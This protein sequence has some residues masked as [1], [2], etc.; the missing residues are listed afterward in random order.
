MA[1]EF[2]RRTLA[3]CRKL[4]ANQDGQW[5]AAQQE[6]EVVADPQAA[7]D[8]VLSQSP[9]FRAI[10]VTPSLKDGRPAASV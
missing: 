10:S 8:K 2:G 6:E 9:G 4:L 7:V 1:A 5:G 3:E